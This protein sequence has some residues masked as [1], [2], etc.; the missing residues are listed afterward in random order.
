MLEFIALLPAG[1]WV[2]CYRP[3]HFLLEIW[4]FIG[5]LLIFILCSIDSNT[6]SYSHFHNYIINALAI[7]SVLKLRHLFVFSFRVCKLMVYLI[8][9]G[10]LDLMKCGVLVRRVCVTLGAKPI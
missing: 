2:L 6:H 3:S 8:I 4:I 1:M 5:S 9:C 10:T 7:S